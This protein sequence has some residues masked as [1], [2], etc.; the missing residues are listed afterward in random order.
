V[1]ECV[2]ERVKSGGID[3]PVYKIA[4]GICVETIGTVGI[5]SVL[6]R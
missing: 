6:V 1:F 3:R 2:F 4:E 5:N